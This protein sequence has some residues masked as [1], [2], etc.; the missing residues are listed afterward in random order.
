M[1]TAPGFQGMDP[2]TDQDA[3][4]TLSQASV[5]EKSGIGLL[6]WLLSTKYCRT[7]RPLLFNECRL[8]QNVYI[9]AWLIQKPS[10]K[11]LWHC[12]RVFQAL[13]DGNNCSWLFQQTCLLKCK[14][15]GHSSRIPRYGSNSNPGRLKHSGTR[16]D[17]HPGWFLDQSGRNIDI[18][19]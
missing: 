14:Q 7:V 6:L 3:C 1:A 2:T 17:I 10:R 4:L 5:I 12:T 18:L 11:D 16:Q 8:E 15:R 19:F 13:F 9:F